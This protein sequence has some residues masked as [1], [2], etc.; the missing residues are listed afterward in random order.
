MRAQMTR[1]TRNNLT[2]CG[3]HPRRITQQSKGLCR[4]VNGAVG[5]A[6]AHIWKC[7]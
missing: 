6:D 5:E 2:P 1:R 4:R 3:M 7:L